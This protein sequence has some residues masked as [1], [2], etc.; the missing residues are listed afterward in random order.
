MCSIT[1]T[2][3][4]FR[5]QAIVIIVVVVAVITPGGDPISLIAL[6]VPMY[7]F[8][9]LSILIGWLVKRRRTRSRSPRWRPR[10]RPRRPDVMA[11]AGHDFTLDPFQLDAIA[12]LDQGRV[13][14]RGGTHR[15]RQDGGGRGGDRHRARRGREGVLHR[16]RSRRCRTRSSST[17]A[18]A[19]APR[20]SACSPVTT[21]STATRRWS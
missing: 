19:S 21:R 3:A 18:S 15:V 7:L 11:S 8:Y 6:S 12:A 4:H 16:A 17:S 5:R 20:P 10:R 1:S 9:E 13:G 14:P 2:L